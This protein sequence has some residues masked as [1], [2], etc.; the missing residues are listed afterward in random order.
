MLNIVIIEDERFA[1]DHLVTTLHEVSEEINILAQLSS[2]KESIDYFSRPSFANL[3]LS[4]V[5]LGDGQSFEIFR[6]VSCSIPIIF[7][8]GYDKFIQEAFD[9]NGIDYL[10]KPVDKQILSKALA[11]YRVFETHFLNHVSLNNLLSQ[12][13]THKKKRFIAYRGKENISLLLEDIVLFYTENKIVYLIDKQGKKYL[14]DKPLTDLNT[15]LDETVFFRANRQY[16]LN[17][18]Y[19]KGYKTFEKVKSEIDLTMPDLNRSIIISQETAPLF[20]EWMHNA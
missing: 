11:K 16:I 5:Q 14:S 3:I 9:N 13:Q 15:E 18:N 4:D 19:I 6:K 7:T 8:T 1:I 20:R 17:I 12:P 2:I 10:H